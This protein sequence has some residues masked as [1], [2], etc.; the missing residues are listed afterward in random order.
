MKIILVIKNSFITYFQFQNKPTSHHP[1]PSA[2]S[3]CTKDT[4][5]HSRHHPA[6]RS[7]PCPHSGQPSQPT[8]LRWR[9]PRPA[10]PPRTRKPESRAGPAESP[11][12]EGIRSVVLTCRPWT[13]FGTGPGTGFFRLQRGVL[14]GNRS[15]YKVLGF[16][17]LRRFGC[18]DRSFWWVCW[19]GFFFPRCGGKL[20]SVLQ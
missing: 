9:R 5:T 2:S 12:R 18:G 10:P 11:N 14:L 8:T 17:S 15:T 6:A 13:G 20:C 19:S 3:L 1:I 7:K 16:R 4:A